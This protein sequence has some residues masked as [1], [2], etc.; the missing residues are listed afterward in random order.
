MG[1]RA[2]AETIAG[3]AELLYTQSQQQ[4]DVNETHSPIASK[5]SFCYLKVKNNSNLSSPKKCHIIQ[6]KRHCINFSY[7]NIGGLTKLDCLR[8]TGGHVDFHGGARG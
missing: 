6:E 2:T 4:T 3:V 5:G 1:Q 8:G 7:L